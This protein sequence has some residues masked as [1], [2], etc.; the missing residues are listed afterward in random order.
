M[1]RALGL[2]RTILNRGG[3]DVGS[4]LAAFSTGGGA[5]GIDPVRS[6]AEDCGSGSER[7]TT[8]S[9]LSSC[10]TFA[11]QCNCD[12]GGVAPVFRNQHLRPSI[13]R[14]EK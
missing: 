7:D 11:G 14:Q 1:A 3:V 5:A 9:D 10:S 4:G 8:A 2:T 13:W 6:C 12:F